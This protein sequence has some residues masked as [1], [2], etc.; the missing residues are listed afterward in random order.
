[1]DIAALMRLGEQAAEIVTIFRR[2]YADV[3][4]SLSTEDQSKL[5][6]ILD[7]IHNENLELSKEIDDAAKAAEK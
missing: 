7:K 5:D 1:M 4:D 3:K 2:N 6:S